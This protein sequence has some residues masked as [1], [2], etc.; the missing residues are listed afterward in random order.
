MD[1]S[2]VTDAAS[3]FLVSDL[4]AATIPAS[5]LRDI[6]D[7]LEDRR[8]LTTNQLNYLRAQGL[9]ALGKFARGEITYETFREEAHGEQLQRKA[10]AEAERQA[11]HAAMQARIAEQEAREAAWAAQQEAVRR[12]RESDP[13]YIAKQKNQALRARY[14]LD[15][16][17]EQD[18]FAQLM[19]ILR[20]IDGG[21]R[22]TDEDVV[23]LTTKGQDYYS[24]ELQIAHHAREAQFHAGEYE[25]TG[26]PWNAVNASSHYRK[27]EQAGRAHELLATIPAG[28]Q[29]APKLRS[30]VATTHGG[31]MRDL[32]RWDEALQFGNQAHALTPNDF[33]PCT[34]LGAVNFELGNFD[35]G[36]DW[37]A[38]AVKRG[39][40]ER[41][42]DQELHSILMRADQ[43]KRDQIT[44]FLLREDPARYGWVRK[45]QQKS[46]R[47]A[48]K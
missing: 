29:K 13:K 22:L 20:R 28:R 3:Y 18:C 26:D 30:A 38:K 2:D 10:A 23:W 14:G 7:K 42:I 40:S 31:V 48:Q 1:A 35:L 45:L 8:P 17:I 36:R 9:A 21:N 41:S 39:A 43:A 47:V 12:A 37:Y 25:R 33:R 32:K 6:L 15:E 24:Y 5:R 11:Q 19:D 44:A 27:C 16:F 34:L 46:P 4:P